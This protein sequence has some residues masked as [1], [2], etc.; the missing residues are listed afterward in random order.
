MHTVYFKYSAK[1][2]TVKRQLPSSSGSLNQRAEVFYVF[3]PNPVLRDWWGLWVPSG[4]TSSRSSWVLNSSLF[5]Q[6]S[7]SCSFFSI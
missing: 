3:S 1:R 7:A 5:K 6:M 2:L 4:D